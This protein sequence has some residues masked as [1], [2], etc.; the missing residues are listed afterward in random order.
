MT[1]KINISPDRGSFSKNNRLESLTADG[2]EPLEDDYFNFLL[3]EDQV[4][5]ER[6]ADPE[7]QKNNLEFELRTTEW[8]IA[9]VKESESYAQNLYAALC[10]NEFIQ[11]DNTW[12]ILKEKYW[13]CSWRY[14]G[15]IVA[16]IQEH[17]DYIDFYCSGI[18]DVNNASSNVSEGIVTDEI[19]TDLEKIGWVVIPTNDN[20]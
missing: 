18:R 11:L 14:A 2:K 13:G 5:M 8:L 16:D 12:D 9:K 10:N 3:R 4:K 20:I 19:K 7:W 1:D 17:G 15:G 6:E